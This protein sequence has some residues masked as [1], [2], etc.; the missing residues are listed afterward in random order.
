[1]KMRLAPQALRFFPSQSCIAALVVAFQAGVTWQA[2]AQW[3][4][5]TNGT[6]SARVYSAMA[7]DSARNRMVLF[8][9]SPDGSIPY[10]DTWCWWS[11]TALWQLLT[12]AGPPPPS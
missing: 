6:P 3:T 8:G 5:L 4:Q 10:N 9:G 11:D 12:P 7:E 1:M 2:A